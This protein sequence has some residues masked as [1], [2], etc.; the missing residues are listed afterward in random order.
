MTASGNVQINANTYVSDGVLSTLPM[1]S[2]SM[3]VMRTFRA[4]GRRLVDF[5]HKCDR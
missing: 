5:K 2:S 3:L 4:F 1:T